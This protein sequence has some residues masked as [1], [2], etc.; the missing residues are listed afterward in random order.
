MN[1]RYGCKPLLHWALSI[2]LVM[3]AV[4]MAHAASRL[5]GPLVTPAWLNAHLADVT[6]LDILATPA[7]FTT[8]P[9][10]GKAG[11]DGVAPLV[12]AGGHIPGARPV[13]FGDIRAPRQ[14]DGRKIDAMLPSGAR[15]QNVMR[16]AG[17]DGGRPIVITATGGDVGTLDMA[18]RLYWTLKTYGTTD[19]A[20][21][22]GGNAAWLQAGFKVETQPAAKKVGNWTAKPADLRWFASSA[23]VVKAQASGTQLVDA[24]STPQFLGITKKPVISEFGH[25]GGARSFPT[26]AIVRPQGAASYFLTSAQY[27]KLLPELGIDAAKPTTTYCNTGHLASGAWF[28]MS[29]IMGN[30]DVRLYDGSMLEWTKEGHPTVPAGMYP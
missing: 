12:A 30:A 14:I 13:A 23:D 22:N 10:Y 7:E 26:D 2:G 3:L 4:P 6:V 1:T 20:I 21:L 18:T 8:A 15:F 16:A 19:I 25:I 11:K 28:V 27:A 29:E 9:R 5:P 17:V 24:R